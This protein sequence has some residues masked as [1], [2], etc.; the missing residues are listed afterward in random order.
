[1]LEP[2]KRAMPSY[3]I[4]KGEEVAKRMI[5]AMAMEEVEDGHGKRT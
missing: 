4:G 5:M 3:F 1:M 2:R